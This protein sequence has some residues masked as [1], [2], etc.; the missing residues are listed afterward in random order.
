MPVSDNRE[1]EDILLSVKTI[2]LLGASPKLE[3]PSNS[4][5]RFL[6]LKDYHVIPVNPGQ[7]GKEI[8]DQ[9]VVASLADIDTPIDMVDVFRS[10][11]HLPTIVK[12]M[13]ALKIKPKVLWTQLGVIHQEAAEL[14]ERAGIRVVM[15]RCPAIEFS[16]LNLG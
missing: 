3:R 11:E 9:R 7:A 6:L 8:H 5:M 13:L 1:I 4:V 2:A 12:E 16:R 10:S 15:N 14:A